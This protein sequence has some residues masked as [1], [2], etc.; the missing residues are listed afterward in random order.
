M[1]IL[2]SMVLQDLRNQFMEKFPSLKLEFY[3]LGNED[4]ATSKTKQELLHD[5]PLESLNP[6]IKEGEFIYDGEMSVKEFEEGLKDQFG[7]NAQVYRKSKGIWL[8]TT[9]TD[10]WSLNTQDGK[11]Y[12]STLD[13]HIEEV[14]VQDYDLE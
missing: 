9:A 5:R 3:T 13:H 10:A 4:E 14:K 1:K 8:Q 7:L 12:R 11:G 2:K 6:N